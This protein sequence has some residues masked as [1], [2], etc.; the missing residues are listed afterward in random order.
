MP[1]I[2]MGVR[3][4]DQRDYAIARVGEVHELDDQP[5]QPRDLLAQFHLL[6]LGDCQQRRIVAGSV[7][8]ILEREW[9]EIREQLT[10]IVRREPPLRSAGAIP[11]A[12][13]S[14]C[15]ASP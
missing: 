15:T 9:G 8:T 2:E 6:D 4:L 11:T 1:P 7:V 5:E 13:G 10:N 3:P 12:A 14:S